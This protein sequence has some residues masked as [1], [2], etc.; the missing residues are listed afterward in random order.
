[1]PALSIL[2]PVKNAAA[3]LEACILS[4]QKQD[5]KQWEWIWVN[6]HST[7]HTP[8]LLAAFAESDPRI[9]VFENPGHGIVPA[10]EKALLESTG[11]FI[12][13]MDADDLMP[14]GRLQ[15]MREAL[16]SSPPKTLVTGLVKYFAET[17][18]SPGYR[19]YENWLN[20]V[21]L[22]GSFRSNLYRECVVA[23]PNWMM[24]KEELEAIGGFSGLAYPEDYDLVFRWLENGFSI[25]TVGETT[26][27]WREHPGRTSRHSPH[28]SQKAFFNLK[29]GRFAKMDYRGGGVILWGTGKKA[30]LSATILK[31]LNIA[32]TR[33][34][35]RVP[36]PNPKGLLAYTEIE[37]IPNPQLLIAV[38]PPAREI[39]K[40]RG[41]LSGIGLSEGQD[42]WFL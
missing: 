27:L 24:R 10:L 20:Q 21:A 19:D 32:C 39:Q 13:R 1:M 14:Q 35:L 38:Y 26:L 41:Y 12:T 15:K 28:Y 4:A 42:Y 5:F 16:Q 8:Q 31:Q 22:E 25:K 6:D 33:M 34:A 9:K 30:D 37:K 7:D 2:T 3:W 29:L 11:R 18:V 23:S 36:R 17:E 40:M